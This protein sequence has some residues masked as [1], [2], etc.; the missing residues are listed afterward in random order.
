MFLR[1]NDLL[2]IYGRDFGGGLSLEGKKCARECWHRY[3]RGKG[4][5]ALRFRP[6]DA[7]FL[8]THNMLFDG[9][10]PPMSVGGSAFVLSTNRAL[11]PLLN[12]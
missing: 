8:R 10:P 12:G 2:C 11:D 9:G 7:F 4:Q 3:E 6:E 5:P 1:D